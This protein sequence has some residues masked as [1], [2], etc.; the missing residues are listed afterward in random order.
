MIFNKP[1]ALQEEKLLGL[2]FNI[3][4][5]ALGYQKCFFFPKVITIFKLIYLLWFKIEQTLPGFGVTHF[6]SASA[7]AC[8]L[9]LFPGS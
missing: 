7:L 8:F 1:L 3:T 2:K 6:T 5:S 9:S 4:V